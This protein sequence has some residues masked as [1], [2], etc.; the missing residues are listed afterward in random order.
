MHITSVLIY[1]IPCIVFAEWSTR[2]YILVA[3]AAP[4][5]HEHLVSSMTVR[6]AGKVRHRTGIFTLLYAPSL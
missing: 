6:A 4:D 2:Q 1:T 3:A 5:L